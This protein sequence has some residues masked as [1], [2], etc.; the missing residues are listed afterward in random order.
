VKV[1]GPGGGSRQ[2]SSRTTPIPFDEYDMPITV[3]PI[4]SDTKG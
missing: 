4:Y 1:L 2:S 3:A